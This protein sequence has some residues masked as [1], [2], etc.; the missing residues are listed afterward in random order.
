MCDYSLMNVKSRAAAVGD[1][2]VSTQFQSTITHGFRCEGEDC[3]TAIC[4]IPGTH[5]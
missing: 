2:L 5:Q 1:K 4:L 3:E